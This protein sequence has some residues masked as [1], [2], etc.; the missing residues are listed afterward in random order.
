MT[1]PRHSPQ[2]LSILIPAAGMGRRM[3]SYGP[4]PLIDLTGSETL[5]GRQVRILRATFPRS[6]LV[7]VLGHEAERILR[8]LPSGV[9]VV[10]NERYA[11]TNVLRSIGMGLRV[12][13]GS[14]V[15]VVYGDLVFNAEAV[16]WAGSGGSSL[17][18][19]SR[20]QI[21]EEEVGATVVDGRV[22]HLGYGLATKWAQ[23]ACLA[24]RE[25]ELFKRVAWAAERRMCFGFEGLNAVIEAGGRFRAV[26]PRGAGIAEVDS[27][28]DIERARV[29]ATQ[30]PVGRL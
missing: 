5:I 8:V 20:G 21:D 15:L 1:R 30:T 3:K 4:K 6:D 25:L 2:D 28:K 7:V 24:G 16:S 23:V 12:V 9:K 13:N 14:R 26:E 10:E 27:A 18:V 19:D 17:L 22:T 29:V 11:E